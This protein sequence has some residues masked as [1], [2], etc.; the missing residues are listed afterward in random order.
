[1]IRK[2]IGNPKDTK[3]FAHTNGHVIVCLSYDG[4]GIGDTAVAWVEFDHREVIVN[5]R[6][7]YIGDK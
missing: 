4:T 6:T 2:P 5:V 7:G 1:M 3:V